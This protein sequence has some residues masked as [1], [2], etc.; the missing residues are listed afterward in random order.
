[1]AQ[2]GAR[3]FFFPSSPLKALNK[4]RLHSVYIHLVNK[5][6]LNHYRATRG[7]VWSI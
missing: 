6:L 4:W 7:Q 2:I 5:I 1:M 3:F